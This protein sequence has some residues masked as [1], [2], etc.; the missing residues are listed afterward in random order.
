MIEQTYVFCFYRLCKLAGKYDRDLTRCEIDE[1]KKDTIAFGGDKCV[2]NG[3][4]FCLNLKGEEEKVKKNNIIESN[5][6]LHAHNGTGF[7]TWIFLNNLSCVKKDVQII[8]NREGVI[9]LKI[10][11]GYTE[12][13]KK[14]IP[15]NFHFRCGMTNL[16][17][18]PERL[19]ITFKLQKKLT[20]N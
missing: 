8:K 2:E 1:C 18:S 7:D 16:K 5:S 6:Q 14:Q 11:N 10:F 15:Q 3:L 9:E 12:H 20:E 4:D 17:F 13:N 19:G